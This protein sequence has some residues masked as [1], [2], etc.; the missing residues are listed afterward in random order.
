MNTSSNGTSII[1]FC[2]ASYKSSDIPA[3]AFRR[4]PVLTLLLVLLVMPV[5]ITPAGVADD[6][7]DAYASAER[8]FQK[9]E[10]QEA[11]RLYR[12]ANGMKGNE[13]DECLLGLART[14]GQ[15]GA[16]KNVI[17]I[18]DQM[19]TIGGNNRIYLVNAWNMR[20]N[21]YSSMAMTNPKRKDIQ[22]LREAEASFR[23]VL[24]IAPESAMAHY[25]LGLVL[26]WLGLNEEGLEELRCFVEQEPEG[27]TAARAR[28]FLKYPHRAGDNFAPDFS[29]VTSDGEFISSEDLQGKVYLLDFWVSGVR[30]V[31]GRFP[32][33]PDWQKGTPKIRSF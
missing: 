8:A 4:F 24:R 5:S 15:L 31:I 12:K 21:A 17:D 32:F 27:E 19:L 1:R 18:C 6:Y 22:R 2:P 3:A 14:Y 9:G 20:G 25:N 7:A 29:M 16:H 11:L 10:Y 30:P 33:F 13:S 23:E 26:I 28:K